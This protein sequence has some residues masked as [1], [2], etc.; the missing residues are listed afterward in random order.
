MDVGEARQFL[1]DHHRAVMVTFRSD[2]RPQ[3]SPVLCGLDSAGRVVV[4]TRETAM[5]VKNL[6]RDPRVSLCVMDDGFF[7][8]WIQ[9][10]GSAEVVPLPEAMEGLVDYYRT[11][12]GEHPDWEDYRAAMERERR[13]LVRF[14]IER[15]GPDRQ[16]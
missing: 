1:R 13:V 3:T 16:G 11:V 5:K 9:V 7:G 4:S 6:R 15:A 8:K 10:D 12:A 2:G 14:E